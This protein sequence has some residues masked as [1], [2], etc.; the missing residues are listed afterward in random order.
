VKRL[1]EHKQQVGGNYWKLMNYIR[2]LEDGLPEPLAASIKVQDADAVN[3]HAE[4]VEALKTIDDWWTE[5]FP[6]GPFAE[7]T[8]VWGGIGQLSGETVA[9]WQKIRSALAKATQTGE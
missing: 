2:A 9:I 1:A 8:S 4:M 7:D 6:Q 3:C 5:S